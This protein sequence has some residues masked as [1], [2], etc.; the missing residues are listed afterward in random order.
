[1]SFIIAL[2]TF[3][4]FFTLS[5]IISISVM[6]LLVLNSNCAVSIGIKTVLALYSY[7]PTSNIAEI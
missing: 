4:I 6:D 7:I 1:M 5:N 3:S 2:L